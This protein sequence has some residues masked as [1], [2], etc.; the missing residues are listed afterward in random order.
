MRKITP[1]V[2]TDVL[3]QANVNR[4]HKLT[5]TKSKRKPTITGETPLLQERA[6]RKSL[7]HG[8]YDLNCARRQMMKETSTESEPTSRTTLRHESRLSCTRSNP[9][10][11]ILQG[12]P[13]FL[14]RSRSQKHHGAGKITE[15]M[16]S[17]EYSPRDSID[18]LWAHPTM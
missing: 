1:P 16:E 3:L 9:E 15:R 8:L 11:A 7:L 17:E 18:S 5:A 14:E 10:D 2:T 6:R 13:V 4:L 12:E